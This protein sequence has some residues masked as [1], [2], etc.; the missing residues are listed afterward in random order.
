MAMRSSIVFSMIL[1]AAFSRVLDHP[2]NFTPILALGLFGSAHFRHRWAAVICPLIALL[3]SDLAL[4]WLVRSGLL[5]GWLAQGRGFPY[6][7]MGAVYAATAAAAL[8]GIP[9][10]RDRSITSVTEGVL[11]SSVLFFLVTNC[12][13][14][15]G[16]DLYPR[17]WEGLAYSYIAGLPYF[18]ATL[19][20]TACYSAVLFGGFALWERRYPALEAAPM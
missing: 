8:L 16:H 12:V 19:L 1:A 9:L 4:E 6:P 3:I 13:F 20:G 5:S 15:P 14:L 17:T 2:V 7:G 18:P 11:S 10:R